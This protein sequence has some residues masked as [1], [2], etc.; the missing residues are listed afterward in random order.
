MRVD[1][2]L[3]CGLAAGVDHRIRGVVQNAKGCGAGFAATHRPNVGRLHSLRLTDE[4]RPLR[5]GVAFRFDGVEFV[6]TLGGGFDLCLQFGA[7]GDD[8]GGAGV[9]IFD[10]ASFVDG[11][12]VGLSLECCALFGHRGRVCAQLVCVLHV[13]LLRGVRGQRAPDGR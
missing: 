4:R 7:A 3:N 13:I 5:D 2:R 12:S 10:R 8:L 11:Q 9:D 6:G 1:Q